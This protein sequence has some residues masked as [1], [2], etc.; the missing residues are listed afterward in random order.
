MKSEVEGLGRM[1]LVDAFK[2]IGKVVDP[3]SGTVVGGATFGRNGWRDGVAVGG[4]GSRREGNDEHGYLYMGESDGLKSRTEKAMRTCDDGVVHRRSGSG[5]DDMVEE[6]R[7]GVDVKR[8]VTCEYYMMNDI[9]ERG[10]AATGSGGC[11]D[12]H[13]QTRLRVSGEIIEMSNDDEISVT[14]KDVGRTRQQ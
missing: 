4:S 11:I 9:G 3:Y 5:R 6:G 1:T 14:S 12:D 13:P 7:K 2:V 8:G 10:V